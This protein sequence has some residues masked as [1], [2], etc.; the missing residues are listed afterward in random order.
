MG[1]QIITAKLKFYSIL[2]SNIKKN[3]IYFVNFY[4]QCL[5]YISFFISES[6][7]Y[8]LILYNIN[9]IYLLYLS[10]AYSK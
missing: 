7:I 8:H 9:L 3:N 10:N 2:S 1:I 4:I 5:F 6:I